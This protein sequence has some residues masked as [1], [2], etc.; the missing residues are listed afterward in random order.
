MCSSSNLSRE[1]EQAPP[2]QNKV[3]ECNVG[4]CPGQIAV[5]GIGPG[6]LMDYDAASKRRDFKRR[7]HC[8]L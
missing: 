5:I 4:N 8:R 1:E 3:Q 7:C 6:S 2:S